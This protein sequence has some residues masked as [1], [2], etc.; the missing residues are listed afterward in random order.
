MSQSSVLANISIFQDPSCIERYIQKM[1]LLL[2]TW[3][4]PRHYVHHKSKHNR[5]GKRTIISRRM[6]A[7]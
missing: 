6:Q 7:S 5:R 3:R 4:S 2:K 1:Q